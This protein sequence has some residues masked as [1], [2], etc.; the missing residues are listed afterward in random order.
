ML[1][2]PSPRTHTMTSEFTQLDYVDPSRFQ[3]ELTPHPF[4]PVPANPPSLPRRYP[5]PRKPRSLRQTTRKMKWSATCLKAGQCGPLH[6][7][8]ERPLQ[9]ATPAAASRRRSPRSQRPRLKMSKRTRTTRSW[10]RT[11]RRLRRRLSG[12]AASCD[13][14]RTSLQM[15]TGWTRTCRPRR[16]GESF[17][18][19]SPS[20]GH[21]NRD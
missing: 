10:I 9:K 13:S 11:T 12:G 8:R 16:S 15:R 4:V 6:P 3:T 2:S 19:G 5:P 7:R 1:Q 17:G 21:R 20:H 14:S 18:P